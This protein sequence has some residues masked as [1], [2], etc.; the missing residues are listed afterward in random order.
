MIHNERGS[1]IGYRSSAE[2]RNPF[3][4]LCGKKGERPFSSE[5]RDA[6][7]EKKY[8]HI[9]IG[10]LHFRSAHLRLYRVSPR[11]LGRDVSFTDLRSIQP[12]EDR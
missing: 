7:A 1:C 5:L 11:W 12:L 4:V 6:Y 3:R 9:S 2:L 8:V 10:D